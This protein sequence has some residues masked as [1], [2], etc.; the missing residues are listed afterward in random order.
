MGQTNRL[1]QYGRKPVLYWYL[2]STWT[3]VC[4]NG[5][6]DVIQ[7]KGRYAVG[8]CVGRQAN[9]RLVD[10]TLLQ[11]VCWVGWDV[12]GSVSCGARQV[13]SRDAMRTQYWPLQTA[14][15]DSTHTLL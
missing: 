5:F 10:A 14:T 11:K 1:F 7:G 13:N 4:E 6:Q 9:A 15:A 2:V 3:C 12:C 8:C